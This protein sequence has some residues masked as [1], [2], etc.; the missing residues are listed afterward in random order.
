MNTLTP[1]NSLRVVLK[2]DNFK[3]IIPLAHIAEKML[4]EGLSQEFVFSLFPLAFH[5]EGVYGLM[6][7]WSE[8]DDQ[9]LKNEI[10]ADL[11]EEIDEEQGSEIVFPKH[12]EKEDYLHFD[13]LEE[14]AKDV[15]EFKKHLKIEIERL[16]GI[17][18]LSKE[19]GIPQSSLSRLLN[20]P[21]LPRR[22]TLAKIAKA[23]NLKESPLLS[24]WI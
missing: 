19:T 21:S 2:Q 23:M 7:M 11:Q 5:F 8:E 9:E 20:S 16:G 13:N 12:L 4:L 18:Q 22:S 10:I 3:Q 6:V 14:I 17:S 15:M 1:N 24:K